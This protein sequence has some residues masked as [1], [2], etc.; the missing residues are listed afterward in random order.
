MKSAY[1]RALERLE[2]QGIAPPQQHALTDETRAAIA[3]VRSRAEAKLAELEI[4][5][6]DRRAGD[7]QAEAEHRRERQRIEANRDRD[8]DRLRAGAAGGS[9]S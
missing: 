7:P 5:H 3:D 1:E 8:I 9:S 4:L 2:A 6:R